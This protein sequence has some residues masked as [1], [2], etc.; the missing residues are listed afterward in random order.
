MKY[1]ISLIII[2]NSYNQCFSQNKIIDTLKFGSFYI[3]NGEANLP[4]TQLKTENNQILG[5]ITADQWTFFHVD[6]GGILNNYKV[7]VEIASNNGKV[8]KADGVN[9]YYLKSDPGIERL[10]LRVTVDFEGDILYIK[11]KETERDSTLLKLDKDVYEYS[12]E[13]Y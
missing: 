8:R 13:I 5:A 9:N 1:I 10:L 7:V 4:L 12:L 6:A 11:M 2:V 3:H